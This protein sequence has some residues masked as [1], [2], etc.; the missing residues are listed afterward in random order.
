MYFAMLLFWTTLL[1]AIVVSLLTK[2]VP[3]FRVSEIYFA[4][5]IVTEHFNL[6]FKG[7]PSHKLYFFPNSTTILQQP[8]SLC[9]ICLFSQ[10]LLTGSNM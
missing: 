9:R 6:H 1:L 7:F 5:H 3:E 10:N 4:L 8:V 2:P